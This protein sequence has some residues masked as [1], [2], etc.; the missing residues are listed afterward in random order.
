MAV[1]KNKSDFNVM[2]VKQILGDFKT[3]LAIEMSQN[4]APNSNYSQTQRSTQITGEIMQTFD[5]LKFAI[6]RSR[7]SNSS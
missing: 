3:E 1:K 5:L 7:G 2:N 4:N 6:A